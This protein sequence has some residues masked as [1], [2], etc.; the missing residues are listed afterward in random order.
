[1]LGLTQPTY[2]R[3]RPRSG[4]SLATIG[5]DGG[6]VFGPES[7]DE[8]YRA[9]EH[10]VVDGEVGVVGAVAGPVE[11]LMGMVGWGGCAV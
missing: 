3:I 10:V 11:L 2:A 9:R 1:M 4:W 6:A 7:Q 8:G 5:G